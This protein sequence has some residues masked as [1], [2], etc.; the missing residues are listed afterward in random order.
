MTEHLEQ[1]LECLLELDHCH[2]VSPCWVEEAS[3]RVGIPRHEHYRGGKAWAACLWVAPRLFQ[4]PPHLHLHLHQARQVH[5]SLGHHRH[6]ARLSRPSVACY[7]SKYLS[8]TLTNLSPVPHLYFSPL[9]ECDEH[10]SF[11]L[12]SPC[13][14]QR[15]DVDS[16]PQ[17]KEGLPLVIA[18]GLLHGAHEQKLIFNWFLLVFNIMKDSK[19]KRQI[20]S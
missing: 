1:L 4:L 15:L 3:A 18:I 13:E 8:S 6:I 17:V 5:Q 14:C 11:L 7:A 12:Q 2:S 19:V 9:Y 16:R 20:Q 10:F